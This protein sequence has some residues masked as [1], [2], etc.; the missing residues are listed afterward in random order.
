LATSNAAIAPHELVARA[1]ACLDR[2]YAPYSQYPVA[3]AVLD[4]QGRIFTGVNVENASYGLTMCAERVAIFTAI[5][6]GA[7]RILAVAVTSSKV[8]P[9][10]P[11]G[12][13]RQV[14]AEFCDPEAPVYCD[15]DS[16]QPVTWTVSALLPNA[17]APMHLGMPDKAP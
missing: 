5:A 17:F 14:M 3:A 6:S 8:S 2:A 1:R 10:T 11:C 12:A 4:D 9:V 7:R 13:C 16:A 15:A